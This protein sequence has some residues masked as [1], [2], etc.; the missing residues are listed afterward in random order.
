MSKH[1][2][3]PWIIKGLSVRATDA[4]ETIICE[5]TGAEGNPI[6][7]ADTRL[8]AAAPEML[9]ALQEIARMSSTTK[10]R[11]VALAAIEKAEGK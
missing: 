9:E 3:G 10:L 5:V 1:T 11:R 8:I 4:R 6:A 2:P 7:V